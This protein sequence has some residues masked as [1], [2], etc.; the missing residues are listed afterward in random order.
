[1]K[2][3]AAFTFLLVS[4]QSFACLG[5]TP[6]MGYHQITCTNAENS[7]TL[8]VSIDGASR[9][10]FQNI[11]QVRILHG[12]TVADQVTNA[13]V[14]SIEIEELEGRFSLLALELDLSRT[15]QI[16]VGIGPERGDF[17]VTSN[18]YRL[19]LPAPTLMGCSYSFNKPRC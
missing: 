8:M 6:S 2:T 4:S 18:L 14:V 9:D 19:N 1:M 5:P 16:S 3:F 7:R 13:K 10:N 15:G 11:A 12:N 17:L